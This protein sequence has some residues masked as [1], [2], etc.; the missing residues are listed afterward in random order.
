[1][2]EQIN[3][4]AWQYLDQAL[5]TSSHV[6]AR[7]VEEGSTALKNVYPVSKEETDRME[8]LVDE[9]ERKAED[10]TET[11]FRERVRELREIISYSRVR[12][13]TWKF[14]L[15]FG[16]IIAAC[17]FW[18]FGNQD[19]E[20]VQRYSKDVELVKKWQKQD[21]TIT[22]ASVKANADQN[23]NYYSR[24]LT[25]ANAYKFERLHYFKGQAESSLKAEREFR[26]KADTASTEKRKESCLRQAD[27]FKDYAKK[28][29]AE[30]DEIA[31][32]DFDGI[33]KLA[34]KDTQLSVDMAQGDA[35][36]KRGWMI[37]L[38]ILIPLYIISGYPYGYMITAHRTQHG[39]MRGLQKAGFAIAS[40]F[41]GSGLL[42]SLL[43][44]DIVK[45]RYADGRTETR[46]E[47]NPT[48]FGIIA[49]K[50]GLMVLGVLIFCFVSVFIMTIETVTGL[51]RN[52]DWAAIFGKISKKE[53]AQA[54]N[55]AK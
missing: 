23:Y 16:S 27:T 37:Y 40:F 39:F 24:R 43:P 55:E 11:A 10:S 29:R 28:H 33:Q 26:Q 9:A 46:T 2:S 3:M 12:H 19:Q 45:Y 21:T 54:L 4:E 25:S 1:M 30:F 42:M 13:R 8:N 36:S 44:D 17:I 41:F 47:T 15:I 48:N 50:F 14:S 7:D 5:F 31:K 35:S 32:L 18:Y 6:N 34:L 38:I 20:R 52:F 53:K 22:Y 51:K 49:M